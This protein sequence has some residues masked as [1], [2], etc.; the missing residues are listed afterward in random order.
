MEPPVLSPLFISFSTR[1]ILG[2]SAAGYT[3]W[4][5]ERAVARAL[6]RMPIRPE[7][8]YGHFMYSAGAAAARLGRE[9][10]I[11]GYVGVGEGR[12]WT[13]QPFGTARAR[14]DLAQAAGFV[15]VS[16]PLRRK[17]IEEL[18]IPESAIRVFPNGPDTSQFRPLD[19]LEARRRLGWP[20]DRFLT[21]TVGNFSAAKGQARVLEAIS[22]LDGVLAVFIGRGERA[23]SGRRVLFAGEWP[24]AGLPE[25]LSACDAFVLPTTH[26][27]SCNAIGEAMA[28][29][30]PVVT[31]AGEFNDDLVDERVA[32]RV[33][34]LSVPQIRAGVAR[35]Q[36]DPGLRSRM[37]AAARER[38]KELDAR[39]RAG[40]ILDWMAR[41]GGGPA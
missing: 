19:R 39:E 2:L 32:L 30:L 26:E 24:H 5:F 37:S 12:F 40:A 7:A 23:P 10:G 3:Q 27:G 8:L 13:I 41:Q 17:L 6:D 15:A 28:C 22:G 1:R 31:S 4:A 9:R 18:G 38:A 16:N 11:P 35:L 36:G 29:G 34:P 21:C 25:V 20:A 33:D 14:R